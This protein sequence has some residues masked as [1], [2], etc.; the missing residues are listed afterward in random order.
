MSSLLG[1]P[2]IYASAHVLEYWLVLPE[3]KLVERFANPQGD[4]YL[5]SQIIAFNTFIE[6]RPELSIVVE[7]SRLQ[8]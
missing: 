2:A 1:N 8:A 5:S 6:S 3:K 7:L 4:L